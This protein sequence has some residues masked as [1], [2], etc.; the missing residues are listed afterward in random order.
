MCR[1]VRSS[2]FSR[3]VALS[4]SFRFPALERGG[5]DCKIPS[6]LYYD[7]NETVRAIGAEAMQANIT[8]RAKDEEWHEVK[9]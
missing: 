4:I 3:R 6:V 5:D 2:H 9:W 1:S 8:E 7:E